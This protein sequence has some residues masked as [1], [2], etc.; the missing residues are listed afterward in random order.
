MSLK[1]GEQL[2]LTNVT[3]ESLVSKDHPYRKI[4]K[5]INVDKYVEK[6]TEL[7]SKLGQ[8]GIDPKKG[9][10]MMFMQVLED[11]S[12]RQMEMA[13]RDNLSV[14]W[15]CNYELT[16]ETPDHSYFHKFRKRIGTKNVGEIFNAIVADLQSKGLCSNAFTFIDS[17]TMTTKVST[18]EERDKAIK[19]GLDKLNND[20]I[21]KYSAD[22][23]ARYGCKGKNKFWFGFKRHHAVDM[24]SGIIKKVAVTPANVPDGEG[25]KKV[26]PKDGGM[27]FADKAYSGKKTRNDIKAAGCYDGGVIYKENQKMKNKD[28]D[29]WTTKV[30]MPFEGGFSKLKDRAKYRGLP[31][32]QMQAFMEAIVHNIKTV[33]KIIDFYKNEGM[34]VL[35]C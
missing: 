12:D 2:M 13:L 7:Y 35:K 18:W 24:K 30:R 8:P 34:S 22:K 33:V 3:V 17:T 23:D 21:N 31:K 26:C 1:Q 16:D 11:R 25:L 20:N 9:F 19:D 10:L 29:R 14:K 5:L 32:V 4:K 28:K 6:Y 27:I 15:F